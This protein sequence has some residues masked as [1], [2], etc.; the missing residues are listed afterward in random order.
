M[1]YSLKMILRSWGRNLLSTTISIVSLTVGLACSLT[2]LLYVLDEH[3]VSQSLGDSRQVCLVKGQNSH[4]AKNGKSVVRTTS[5]SPYD[6]QTYADTYPEIERLVM[7]SDRQYTWGELKKWDPERPPIYGVYE[8]LA[9]LFEL[10]TEQGD[11]KS[12]V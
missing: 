5:V 10:P 2:L 6:M 7:F 11:R 8:G 4:E 9:D 3:K 12:V 1:L